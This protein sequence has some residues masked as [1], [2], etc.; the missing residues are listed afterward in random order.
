[1]RV[2]G[3]RQMFTG[4]SAFLAT[5]LAGKLLDLITF[6][7][8]YTAA[9]GAA[10]AVAGCGTFFLTRLVPAGDADKQ[11]ASPPSLREFLGTE[12]SRAL[13]KVAVPV[14][15]FNIGFFMLNPVINLYFVEVLELSNAQIGLLSAVFVIA[16]TIGS[17][18]WGA[19]AD[20]HGNHTVTIAATLGLAVQ[21]IG[22][23]L[24][25]SLYYLIF[26]QT[27]GG[28][29]FAGFLLATFNTV[30]G[31]GDRQQKTLVVSSYHFI[32]NM[33]SFLAPFLGTWAYTGP[34]L[35]AAFLLAGL[36]RAVS[37]ALLL[38]GRPARRQGVPGEHHRG[39]ATGRRAPRGP[40][41]G[42]AERV[43]FLSLKILGTMAFRSVSS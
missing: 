3:V 9:F 33:A 35:V 10:V 18:L 6:P 29:C 28:F 27:V 14:G 4:F 21:A 34:G 20:R 1:G 36:L 12:A 2:F 42:R 19:L 39:I 26:V 11:E 5:S 8:N 25:P 30:I 43:R 24:S 40:G 16:Q 23:W 41:F 15:V 13:W 38:Q 22:Y 32:G 37:A 7:Y 31:I 17:W